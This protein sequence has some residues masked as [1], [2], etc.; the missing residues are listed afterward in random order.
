MSK[1]TMRAFSP[2]FYVE[3]SLK[4]W[5]RFCSIFSQEPYFTEDYVIMRTNNVIILISSIVLSSSLLVSAE[6]N[7]QKK[8]ETFCIASQEYDTFCTPENLKKYRQLVQIIKNRNDGFP[9]I[10]YDVWKNMEK[11]HEK[12]TIKLKNIHQSKE[13]GL[14]K[15][16]DCNKIKKA[17]TDI[18]ISETSEEIANRIIK[19]SENDPVFLLPF[20]YNPTTVYITHQFSID[21]TIENFIKKVA[22]EILYDKNGFTGNT[23][24]IPLI[25]NPNHFQVVWE[26]LRLEAVFKME[27][28]DTLYDPKSKTD[29][30]T[31]NQ[32]LL[33]L[34]RLPHTEAR[35]VFES[36]EGEVLL[37]D[38]YIFILIKNKK[39]GEELLVKT[40]EDLYDIYVSDEI[41][42]RLKQE[43]NSFK[44]KYGDIFKRLCKNYTDNTLSLELILNTKRFKEYWKKENDTW[45]KNIINQGGETESVHEYIKNIDDQLEKTK[46]KQKE[47]F[48]QI[49]SANDVSLFLDHPGIDKGVLNPL[50]EAMCRANN[51]D[52]PECLQKYGQ[53][54]FSPEINLTFPST[55]ENGE[56]QNK[57]LT[58][59]ECDTNEDALRE[60]TSD[61]IKDWNHR[62]GK[63]RG[64][65]PI[66][67]AHPAIQTENA[68]IINEPKEYEPK[69]IGEPEEL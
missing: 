29:K 30:R 43:I 57:F 9:N 35:L 37:Q 32:V 50:V 63:G 56:K 51:I 58:L 20:F 54:S 5:N 18:H 62:L 66:Q 2:M 68:E 3:H 41:K 1:V 64:Y 7:L 6:N 40:P 22:L 36:E 12:S 38:K 61:T 24:R 44:E 8:T 27:I 34:N 11:L 15:A 25:L 21:K 23:I 31:Y 46:N 52:I 60:L 14:V 55:N 10:T 16:G 48:N 45:I 53:Y 67:N 39:T 19:N 42:E 65:V 47:F 49:L 4:K 28:L 69:P 13:I 17:V 33:D 59:F 26:Y